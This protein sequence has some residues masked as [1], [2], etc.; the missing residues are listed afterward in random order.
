MNVNFG[1]NRFDI[2]VAGA[3]LHH[4]R[5]DLDWERTFQKI[6]HLLKPGGTF[7]IADLVSQEEEAL[8]DYMW[9][10]YSQYLEKIGGL[11]YRKKV[12][13]YIEKEDSPRSL[14]FQ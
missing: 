5:E 13:A 2:I 11:D 6:Y 10:R 1:N 7:M 12:L 9:L 14:S 3:V 4:L 8:S